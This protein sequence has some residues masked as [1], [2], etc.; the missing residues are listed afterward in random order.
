MANIKKN[1]IYNILLSVS[2]V[3]FPLITFPYVSRVL[4]PQGIG[5]ISFVESI[6]QYFV[7]AAAL[8]IPIYAVREIAKVRDNVSLRSNIFSELLTVH[9]LTT[10]L[11]ILIYVTIF[12]TFSRLQ[13][14]QSLF[15][16]GLGILFFQAFVMEWL[17]QGLEEFPYIAKRTILVR[18]LSIIAIFLFVKRPDQ[19]V[20]YYSI[21]LLTILVNVVL[22]VLYAR[23]F[24]YLHW[25]RLVI[26]RHLRPLL[27]ISSLAMVTSVYT[28][29]DVTIL[30]FLSTIEQVGYYSAAIRIIK[31]IVMVFVAFATVMVPPLSKAFHSEDMPTVNRLLQK[32]FGYI[33]FLNVPVTVGLMVI[34]PDL[35]KLYAGDEFVAAAVSLRWLAPTIIFISLSNIFGMQIL[36]PINQEKKFFQASLFG[37]FISLAVNFSLIPFLGQAGAAISAMVTECVVMVLLIVFA[38]RAVAFRPQWR[39][40]TQALIC[41]AIFIPLQ[42]LIGSFSIGLLQRLLLMI[43]SASFSYLA[44]QYLVFGNR[45]IKELGEMLLKKIVP[46]K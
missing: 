42:W 9:V 8:G 6:T 5:D 32:S 18:V 26:R 39:L 16:V 12:L 14:Y 46:S 7:L 31:L 28:L 22:N 43:I 25:N 33:V 13:T 21:S 36:N 35:L 40:L 1:A 19:A 24:V 10:V 38:L 30:G 20:V 17:F 15:M 23:R 34:A 41:S 37:M 2:Q 4:G 27:Y 29:L 44:L 11:A 3:L 45:Y